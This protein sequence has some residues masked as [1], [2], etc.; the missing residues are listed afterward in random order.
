MSLIRPSGCEPDVK[1]KLTILNYV[2]DKYIEYVL[3][4]F[5]CHI[6]YKY[7]V[8]FLSD[9]SRELLFYFYLFLHSIIT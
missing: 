1:L 9:R 6:R 7:T 2:Q 5:G 3:V 8:T 4:N